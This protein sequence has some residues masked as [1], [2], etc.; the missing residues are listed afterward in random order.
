MKLCMFADI[1]SRGSEN[2][3]SMFS[4]AYGGCYE[5]VGWT[6]AWL[7]CWPMKLTFVCNIVQGDS[8][9]ASTVITASIVKLLVGRDSSIG[10]ATRYGLDGPGII[11]RWGRDFP[12]PSRTTLAP[13]QPLIKCVQI[14]ARG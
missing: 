5:K 4:E 14:L 12:H 1:I 8:T 13:T 10:I 7:L 3:R 11:F 9:V 6:V 2:C